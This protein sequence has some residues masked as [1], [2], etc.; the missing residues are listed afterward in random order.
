MPKVNPETKPLWKCPRCG[1]RFVTPNMWHSCRQVDLE[2]HFT[3]KEPSIR[4]LFDAWL[5]FVQ[6]YG[7]PLTVIPQ[8]SRISFQ[9]RVRFSGAI[10]HKQW[11]DCTFW[12]KRSIQDDWFNRVEKI[13]P[14]NYVYHFKLT[15]TAQL[16]E[17]LGS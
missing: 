13:S 11:V 15:D 2:A 10:I 7:G 12:L 17:R 14:I 5:A 3:G 1:H 6:K 4:K 8:K 9:A 16:D